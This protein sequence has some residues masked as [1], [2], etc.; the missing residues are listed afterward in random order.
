MPPPLRFTSFA[1]S[2]EFV[3]TEWVVNFL[4]PTADL[5]HRAKRETPFN[6]PDDKRSVRQLVNGMYPGPAIECYENDTVSALLF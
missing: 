5:G 1:N 3:V 4:R 6:I 2:Y